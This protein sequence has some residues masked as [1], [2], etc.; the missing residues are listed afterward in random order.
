MDLGV[1][2]SFVIPKAICPGAGCS[3]Y[4]WLLMKPAHD[5]YKIHFVSFF[6]LNIGQKTK[7]IRESPKRRATFDIPHR[8]AKFRDL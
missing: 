8:T 4:H 3:L 7:K 6:H 1:K 2:S 5:A